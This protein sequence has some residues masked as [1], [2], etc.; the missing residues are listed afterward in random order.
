MNSVNLCKS[1]S[2]IFVFLRVLGGEKSAIDAQHHPR[3][4]FPFGSAAG[5][6][7]PN[8]SLKNAYFL[9]Q[10][11]SIYAYTYMVLQNFIYAL[12]GSYNALTALYMKAIFCL[13][14]E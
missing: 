14:S 5:D 9:K 8:P 2:K 11:I 4:V 6:P 10:S 12:P 13:S 7:F 1:V 3:E